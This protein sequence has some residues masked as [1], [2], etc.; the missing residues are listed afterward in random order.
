MLVMAN[1]DDT[2]RFID[3][4]CHL[5]PGDF[6]GADGSDE[7]PAVLERAA[8]AGLA[9]MVVIGSGRG[10]AEV[11]NTLAL[12][13]AHDHLF[14]AVGVHPHDACAV[15]DE[16]GAFVTP[17]Q[18][19]TIPDGGVVGEALFAEVVAAAQDPRVVAVGET[20][21]DYHYKHSTPGQQRALLRRFVRLSQQVDKPL[22]LHLRDAQAHEEARAILA[23]EGGASA[24]GVVHCFTGDAADA[25]RWLDLG[26]A[27]SYSGIV[28]F[29]S[30]AAIQEACR[31]TPPER[32]LLETDCPYLA[33]VPLRGRR[34]EPAYLTHTAAF[35]ARLRGEELA[36][37]AASSVAATR[38]LFR[39]P[40]P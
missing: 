40:T 8:A 18:V 26:F 5:E 11:R 31:L 6:R 33:P 1:P 28:T 13:R 30:A 39:L 10:A 32:L 37:L 4:H 19:A 38:R 22:V 21:L 9:Q 36:A 24:G 2:L 23:E 25:R 17:A 14:A 7:R 3:S 27:L 20:G 16:G 34:N 29:K 15:V 35:V 12:C